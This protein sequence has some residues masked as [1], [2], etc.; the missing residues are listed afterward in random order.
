MPETKRIASL[1]VPPARVHL[2][3]PCEGS[4][5]CIQE[6]QPIT[7]TTPHKTHPWTNLTH[8]H[9]SP[10]WQSHTNTST[11]PQIAV[12]PP[13]SAWL[14]RR[15]SGSCTRSFSTRIW[16]SFGGGSSSSSSSGHSILRFSANKH[17]QAN[18]YVMRQAIV[19]ISVGNN[20]CGHWNQLR[21]T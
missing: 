2:E 19:Q 4:R 14:P 17:E 20:I 6:W 5:G 8:Q 21:S 15:M 9:T 7:N 13:P 1:C 3:C 10:T 11:L 18:S 16:A 12:H